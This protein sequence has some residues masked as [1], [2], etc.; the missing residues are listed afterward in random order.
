M[1][2]LFVIVPFLGAMLAYK[3]SRG[4]PIVWGPHRDLFLGA[5]DSF[6]SAFRRARRAPSDS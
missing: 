2:T 1:E 3:V 6:L 5:R 4:I